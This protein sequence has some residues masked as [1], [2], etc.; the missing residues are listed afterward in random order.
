MS[1]FFETIKVLDNK[2][3]NLKYHERRMQKSVSENFGLKKKFDLLSLI[4]PPDGRFYRCKVYYTKEIE[5]VEFIKYKPRKFESFKL[6][7]SD[8]EY[9]YKFTDREAL[10]RLSALKGEADDIII[11]KN[12]FVRDTSIANLAFFI[13]NR[14]ITPDTP[15]LEGTMRAY[16][17]DRGKIFLGKISIKELKYARKI[18]IMNALI[19]FREINNFKILE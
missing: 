2:A 16:L 3:Y 12:G 17:L 13:E 6:I 18:A 11:L 4:R 8:V 1:L 15:L 7:E 19:G 5:K 14:W 10:N 9:P